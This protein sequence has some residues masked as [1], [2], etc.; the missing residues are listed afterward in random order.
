MDSWRVLDLF[1]GAGGFSLGFQL[2]GCDVIGAI[3]RDTWAAD[4]FAVNH[5]QAE[6]IV[7]DIEKISQEELLE[8]FGKLRPSI[9]V[10]GPPCQGFSVCRRDAGDPSDPRN[11]LFE[12]FIRAV[13]TLSPELVV[14]ENVPNLIKARTASKQL[15]IEI[16]CNELEQLGYSVDFKN[17]ESVDFGVPQIRR[18]LF[19]VASKATVPNKFPLPTHSQSP[20]TN[21]FE[22]L[23]P[24]PTLW[25]AISDLPEIKAGEGAEVMEYSGPPRNGYQAFLRNGS[26]HVLNHKAM[27]HSK[28]LVERFSSMKCG[29]TAAD[30]PAHLGPLARNGNGVRS[31]KI[32]DQN[33][34]RMHPNRPCHTI[35]AAFYA[36]FVHPFADRNFTP[37]E[38]ARIQSFPDWYEFKGK[39]TVVSQ[40][41]LARE[42]RWDEKFLCQ[43]NQIGNAVPP[44]LARALAVNLLDQLE[45]KHGRSIRSRA[46]SASKRESRDEI[47]RP[48]M[49][50]VSKRDTSGIREVE[51][52]QFGP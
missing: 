19:V 16:I 25:E 2:A 30:V 13:S 51:D 52:R 17:L 37:R 49:Q 1:A 35:P 3:E 48:E 24:T 41:L 6:V 18:R 21:L 43:Y 40:K 14:M 7:K 29:D 46:K 38:G 32:Y 23:L 8:Q 44:L 9:I 33:N 22:A 31:K 27:R 4:T 47:Q 26:R 12:E 45:G 28:R 50:A 34:R 39:P 5:P 11:S 10:G 42:E 20:S 15:V 36:N